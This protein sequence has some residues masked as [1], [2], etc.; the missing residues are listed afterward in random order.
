MQAKFHSKGLT[1]S[2]LIVG[3]LFKKPCQDTKVLTGSIRN[4]SW[5]DEA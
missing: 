4:P 5:G 1:G 2:V 3:A